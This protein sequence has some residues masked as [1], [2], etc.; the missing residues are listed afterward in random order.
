[1]K[2]FGMA[3]RT[4]CPICLSDRIEPLWRIP[5]SRVKDV[6]VN[7]AST[8]M[9]PILDTQATIYCYSICRECESLFL[10]PYDNGAREAYKSSTFH[11]TKFD[12]QAR[13]DG[14]RRQYNNCIKPMLQSTGAALSMLDAGCGTAPYLFCAMEDTAHAFSSLIGVELSKPSIDKI[15]QEAQRRGLHKMHGYQID[16]DDGHSLLE[17]GLPPFDFIVLSEVFEHLE[18]PTVGMHSLVTAMAPGGRIFYTA[19][20]PGG[21]LPVRPGEPIYMSDEGQKVL[22]QRLGLQALEIKMEAGR[23]KTVAE[24]M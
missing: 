1:M 4:A 17:L 21:S 20:C 18:H 2:I 24:K 12:D 16:L 11:S 9:L 3:L 23:W 10:N 6:V 15:N 22:L 13:M 5:F 19:Q 7:G 8:G 14:Y